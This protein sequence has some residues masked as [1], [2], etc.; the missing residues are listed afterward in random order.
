MS[1]SISKIIFIS[2]TPISKLVAN[3]LDIPFLLESGFKIEFWD[4]SAMY[5]N[6]KQLSG[7]FGGAPDYKYKFPK[8]KQFVSKNDVLVA[9]S[10]L[11]NDNI[12]CPVDFGSLND[13]WL[14]RAFRK[15]DIKYYV[16][17]TRT[18]VRTNMSDIKDFEN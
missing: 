3:K 17:P 12:F 8:E 15:F 5:Y 6:Q 1:K 11:S 10:Q 9:L 16:G 14:R 4:L 2:G 18:P 7:Y 13:F